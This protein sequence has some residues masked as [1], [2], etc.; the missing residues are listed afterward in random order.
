MFFTDR[1][2][3]LKLYHDDKLK[4]HKSALFIIRHALYDTL[5][6]VDFEMFSDSVNVAHE[7]FMEMV[8]EQ[9]PIHGEF[10]NDI[11]QRYYDILNV[12]PNEDSTK[13]TENSHLAWMLVQLSRG[14]MSET[15]KH[16]WLGYIQGC[17]VSKGILDVNEERDAT[18]QVFNG[19]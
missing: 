19:K 7:V 13:P 5:F 3:L 11:R 6:T 15:K 12:E 9:K 16:R 1:Q 18:R 8:E 14:T 10:Y 2:R 4:L 17:M